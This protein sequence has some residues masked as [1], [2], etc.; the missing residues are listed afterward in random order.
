MVYINM[1]LFNKITMLIYS[2]DH[3]PSLHSA[4]PDPAGEESG[5]RENLRV[6]TEAKGSGV[7]PL[8]TWY[9]IYVY[10]NIYIYM[11]RERDR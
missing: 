4:D 9:V 11:Y 8:G 7:Q 1:A 5:P 6:R 3:P 2:K 10:I